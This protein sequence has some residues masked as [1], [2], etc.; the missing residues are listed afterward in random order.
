MAHTS[1][2]PLDVGVVSVEGFA[3]TPLQRLA[4][5]VILGVVVSLVGVRTATHFGGTPQELEP[6]D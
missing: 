6:S 1:V 5:F 4:V 3:L 2:P